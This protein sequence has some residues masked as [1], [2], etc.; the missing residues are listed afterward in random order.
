VIMKT[1]M[2]LSVVAVFS[3]SPAPLLASFEIA[4]VT[5][6]AVDDYRGYTRVYLDYGTN[7]ITTEEWAA[8]TPSD[9]YV[10]NTPRN[11]E[12]ND[13]NTLSSPGMPAP[14]VQV[15]TIDGYTWKFIAQTQ[16]AMWPY[17]NDV[18]PNTENAYEAA[19]VTTTPPPGTIKFSSNEKNQQM[20]FWAR[21]GNSPTN[22]PIQ[23]YFITD[24]WGNKYIMGTTGVASD[25][26]IPLS[27]TSSVLPQ[28]WT[29]STGYLDE[30]LTLSP[31]YGAGDQAHFNLFR[32]NADNSFFQFEWGANG[33]SVASQIAG[34]P[35]WGGPS[36]DAILGRVGDDNLIHGAEGDDTISA[37]GNNDDIYGDSGSDTVALQGLLSDYQVVEWAE[38]GAHMKLFGFGLT[39]S[40]YDTEFLRFSDGSTIATSAVPE[41]STYALLAMS[42]A[43]ALWWARRRR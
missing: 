30:T 18:F 27:F 38:Q 34:M 8:Y 14:N 11:S 39:K 24:E 17:S 13:E 43:G 36:S 22:N 5:D 40:L 25:A 1:R 15:V 32:E 4:D 9:G 42:A 31:A 3:L 35:I 2:L 41:P 19:V 7:P 26:D 12:F 20:I 28:G 16:S 21:E 37:L 10:K 33:G 29:K 6:A 23:R